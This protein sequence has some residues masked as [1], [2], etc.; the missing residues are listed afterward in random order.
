MFTVGF[1]YAFGVFEAQYHIVEFPD[2]SASLI[3]FIGS[4]N[5]AL[6]LSFCVF[7]GRAAEVYGYKIITAIGILLYVASIIG[8]SF[9]TSAGQT[10][11]LQGVVNG[12]AQSCLFVPATAIPVPYFEKRLSVAMGVSISLFSVSL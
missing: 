12:I 1:T 11:A 9:S 7:I 5:I 3:S 10:I 8:A 2:S 4:V 6:A